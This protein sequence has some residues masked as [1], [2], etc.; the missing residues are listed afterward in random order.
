MIDIENFCKENNLGTVLNIERVS[1]GFMHKMF[2]V[3]TTKGIYAVKVLNPEVIKRKNAYDN[4]ILSEEISNLAK[5]NNIPVA[6]AL[7]ING[8]YVIE[9]KNMSYMVF[10]YIE[11]KVLK[12]EEITVEHCKKIGKILSQIH[13][14]N[15]QKLNI[16][17]KI[18][19]DHFF[20]DWESF[21]YN[22][23]FENMKYKDLYLKNYKKYYSILRRVVERYN[24]SNQK[25]TICHKD[26]DPKNVL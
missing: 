11:G 22:S 3:E 14:L 26:M 15:Y 10:D 12:D 7:K 19:E 18:I 16:E 24:A 23:N 8:N 13:N 6:S 1:G 5:E 25:Q 4:F 17:N 20:V 21:I 2:K 9:Y